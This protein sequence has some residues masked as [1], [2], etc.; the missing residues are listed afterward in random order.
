MFPRHK[1]Q[2]SLGVSINTIKNLTRSCSDRSVIRFDHKDQS[3]VYYRRLK[4]TITKDIINIDVDR[5]ITE[6]ENTGH[7]IPPEHAHIITELQELLQEP[8]E[9]SVMKIN[10]DVDAEIIHLKCHVCGETPCAYFDANNKPICMGC[11]NNGKNVCVE[12]T[13]E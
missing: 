6:F 4:K 5:L 13:I 12:E 2:E 8:K 1:I 11:Y 3:V 9:K 7:K 10:P